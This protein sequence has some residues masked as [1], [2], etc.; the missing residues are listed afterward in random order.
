MQLNKPSKEIIH[1]IEMLLAKNS[2]SLVAVD[3]NWKD[4]LLVSPMNDG[5]MG[6]LRLFTT[7]KF[8]SKAV[9]GQQVS[10][11]HFYDKDGVKVIVSLNVDQMGC[12]FEL[13]V[14]K[15]D[16]SKLI[17]IPVI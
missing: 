15:T 6:S 10:E 14:W 3:L 11:Y 8:N 13:D 17:K 1:L 7:G 4:N 16:F 12:L 5:G 9:F 2:T